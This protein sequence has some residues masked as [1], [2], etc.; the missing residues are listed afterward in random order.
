MPP[1]A[2]KPNPARGP[3]RFSGGRSKPTPSSSA[4]GVPSSSFASHRNKGGLPIN[5]DARSYVD[6]DLAMDDGVESEEKGE[7]HQVGTKAQRFFEQAYR[8]YTRAAKLRPGSG[9]AL[10]NAARVQYLLATQF[11]LPPLSVATLVDSVVLFKM[12][13]QVAPLPVA[14]AQAAGTL[15]SPFSLD[16]VS[17]LATSLHTLGDLVDELGWLDQLPAAERLASLADYSAFDGAQGDGATDPRF[18]TPSKLLQEAIS[19]Y[20]LASLGQQQVLLD[21]ARGGE[22][23][24]GVE[25]EEAAP[26]PGTQKDGAM[27]A[28][29]DAADAN[30]GVTPPSGTVDDVGYTSS[31]V[32]VDTYVDTLLSLQACLISLLASCTTVTEAHVCIAGALEALERASAALDPQSSGGGLPALD[33]AE[34]A[35]K[36]VELERAR[37]SLRVGHVGRLADLQPAFP[38]GAEEADEVEKLEEAVMRWSNDV[39]AASSRDT[40]TLCELGDAALALCRLRLR[41]LAHDTAAGL[42][43]P[44][45]A[46]ERAWTLGTHASRL[47]NAALS[48]LS[49]TS[50]TT[51]PTVVLGAQNASTPTSRTRGCIC[52]SLA[53]TSMVRAHSIFESSSLP[54]AIDTRG[55]LLDNARVYARK[56]CAEFA[57]T[58]ILSPS[59]SS[60]QQPNHG[61]WETLDN[62]SLAVFT[63]LRALFL[64]RGV[65]TETEAQ[66]QSE[67]DT[68]LTHLHVIAKRDAFALAFRSGGLDQTPRGVHRFVAQIRDEEGHQAVDDVEAAFWQKVQL[69]IEAG[70]AAV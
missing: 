53:S 16:V 66:M 34:R 29:D 20:R 40:A 23:G 59:S 54:N 37:L 14:E 31:L 51:T 55:K 64:R 13:L 39:V 50:A 57:W 61:G 58:W 19:F 6:F 5:A 35:A 67:V 4:S 63:L 70:G 52:T 65:R 3:S 24:T 32:T 42:S 10:Y 9:D 60:Q 48:T 11:Y 44:L 45:A 27:A 46:V 7:R 21:Q 62:E 17:N 69:Y 47:F 56:A 25:G 30:D 68:V 43:P 1:L 33:E 22:G 12:A 26:A 8:L 36:A 38:G 18:P 15:P 41:L 2:S 28:S 49:T